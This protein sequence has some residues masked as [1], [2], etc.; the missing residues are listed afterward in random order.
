MDTPLSPRGPPKTQEPLDKQAA[1]RLAGAF[2]T[3]HL[4][5][6]ETVAAEGDTVDRCYLIEY[7][8]VEVRKAPGR[9]A[10]VPLAVTW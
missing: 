9:F 6:G 2:S 8:S 5:R 7:G 10:R 1:S 3:I 4:R